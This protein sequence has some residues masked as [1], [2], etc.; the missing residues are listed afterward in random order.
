MIMGRREIARAYLSSW[1]ALDVASALPYELLLTLG[2]VGAVQLVKARARTAPP[3]C[4]C[5][6]FLSVVCGHLAA[7]V[8][9]A[10]A[11]PRGRCAQHA[12][13]PPSPRVAK[14]RRR[15]ASSSCC[16]CCAS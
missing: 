15:C 9:P 14:P 13:K 5:P 6:F 2:S 12:L 11:R 1:F 8:G 7:G 4:A 16:A 3:P 10:G